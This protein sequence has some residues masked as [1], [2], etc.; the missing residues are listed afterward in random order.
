MRD[1]PA[2]RLRTVNEA[3]VRED[4]AFVLYWMIAARRPHWNHALDHAVARAAALDRPLVVL[5]PLRVGYEWASDRLHRFVLE[6][7]AANR[8][9]FADSAVRYYPYVEP[10]AGAGSGLLET[11]GSHA[12]E[13][14]TDEFPAFFLPRMI[15]AAGRKLPVRLT[16]V[17]GNGL[18]PLRATDRVFPTAYAFRRFL[19][20]TLRAH[21]AHPPKAH[22][23]RGVSLPRASVPRDVLDRWPE[24]PAAWLRGE[25]LGDL[26]IDHRV[27]PVPG[28]PGGHVAAEERLAAFVEER[29]PRYAEDRNDP[30]DEAASGLSPYLHFGHV[31]AH[32]ILDAVGGRE[33]LDPA[34]LPDKGDGSRRGWWGLS[35]E[36][37]GFLDQLATW[38]ELGFNFCHHR[39]EDAASFDA[40][41][42]WAIETLEEHASDERPY[43]YSL[44]EFDRAATHDEIWNAAQRQLRTEGRIHNYLR[45][46]WGKKILHWTESPRE[47]AAV[48]IELNNRYAIDGRDPNSYSGI[49]WTLGRYDR[50]WGPERKVFGKIRYMS[51]DNT[52]RKLKLGPYLDRYGDQP[53]LF[54]GA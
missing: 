28:L 20:K 29:L 51:S 4:G 34:S 24:A 15:A 49:F 40:L 42:P 9:A 47:A 19:Q 7:M 18:L 10:E 54:G 8:E 12:A 6:G 35:E 50:P 38:R 23:L 25:D 21:L 16:A 17:D 52:R 22:P 11:L 46:L 5:E 3:P 13:V 53:D 2:L 33:D 48:M 31:S 26:P 30:S 36:A 32:R 41:P 45:M 44:D 43:V 27:A 39:G 14:V 37:E 1:V